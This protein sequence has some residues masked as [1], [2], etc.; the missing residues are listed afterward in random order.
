MPTDVFQGHRNTGTVVRLLISGIN[1]LLICHYLNW[2]K[3]CQLSGS[4]N[5]YWIIC[6]HFY[7][8]LRLLIW[9]HKSTH[10]YSFA[11]SIAA[12]SLSLAQFV[13]LLYFGVSDCLLLFSKHWLSMFWQRE[14]QNFHSAPRITKKHRENMEVYSK[15]HCT[16]SGKADFAMDSGTICRLR[17]AKQ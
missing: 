5:S 6:G 12:L 17:A 4:V 11:H 16:T 1:R 9:L 13:L 7:G 14:R 8:Q 15:P 3:S 10:T 2:C